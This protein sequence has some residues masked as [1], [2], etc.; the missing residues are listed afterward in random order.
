MTCFF[1]ERSGQ[2]GRLLLSVDLYVFP[3]FGKG[4]TQLNGVVKR[5]FDAGKE[6]ASYFD[7]PVHAITC[8]PIAKFNQTG[9]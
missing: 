4:G 5:N 1:A 9:E 8:K 3:I 6:I 7:C 2:K